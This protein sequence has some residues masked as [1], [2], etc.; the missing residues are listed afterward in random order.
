M[1]TC[2]FSIVLKPCFRPYALG[3]HAQCLHCTHCM[4]SKNTH[5]ATKTEHKVPYIWSS[6]EARQLAWPLQ[7]ERQWDDFSPKS[8]AEMYSNDDKHRL[9]FMVNRHVFSLPFILWSVNLKVSVSGGSVV[10]NPPAHAGDTRWIPGSGRS[11]GK[12]NGN[13]SCIIAWKI[14]QT[15]E[16]G[17]LQSIRSQRVWHDWAAKQQTSRYWVGQQ[18][19]RGL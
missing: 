3:R 8:I 14:P 7:A 11:P 17:G 5:L 10:E 2:Y 18:V 15:E 1:R 16:P 13:H 12:G 6:C 9:V 19:H 4:N